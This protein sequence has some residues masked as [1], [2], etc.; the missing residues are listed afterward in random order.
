M[1]FMDRRDAG[2]KLANRLDRFR[3]QNVIV[4]ALPRGGVVI[5]YELAKMLHVPLDLVITRK[6][7]HPENPE[8][9]VCVVAEDGHTMCS[10]EEC[11][12]LD[13]GWLQ[14]AIEKE[15]KEAGRRRKVYL[16]GQDI[17]SPE[18]KIAILV[19]DGVATGLTFLLAIRELKHRHPLKTVAAIP[20]SPRDTADAIRQEVDELVTVEI[21]DF[22][23]GAVG[24]YYDHFDQTDD[25]EVIAL[26]EETNKAFRDDQDR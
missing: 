4:Y 17:R 12:R 7:G 18:G 24:A 25:E 10:E 11:Q 19:D 15:R 16:R 1:L 6:V 23:L 26:L 14:G 22:Y 9:A 20:V 5:G 13:E 8:Y 21:P 3:G 2:R